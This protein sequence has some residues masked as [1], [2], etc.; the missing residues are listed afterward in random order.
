MKTTYTA[1][2]VPL[3]LLN[4]WW[5]KRKERK[6]EERKTGEDKRGEK[7]KEGKGLRTERK[8]RDQGINKFYLK[9]LT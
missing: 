9:R 1:L 8:G 5:G 6:G 7:G 3:S 4:L 2:K